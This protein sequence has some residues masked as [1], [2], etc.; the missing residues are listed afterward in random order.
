MDERLQKIGRH[1]LERLDSLTDDLIGGTLTPAQYRE[2]VA[3]ALITDQAAAYMLGADTKRL[4]LDDQRTI[5][6]WNKFQLGYLDG[7]VSD[8]E[9]GRYAD[10]EAMLRARAR[11]YA[12]AVKAPY[13]AGKAQG[14]IIP[15]W[16]L[17]GLQ[18]CRSNCKCRLSDVRDNGD[19]SG[20][21]SRAMNG[22]EPHCGT[23]PGLV[24]D[25]VVYRR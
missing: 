3:R 9:S 12:G 6:Q 7:F 14:W 2:A 19:G 18:E 16:L 13:Y 8:I 20:V 15:D 23:C 1:L 11:M 21:I 10:S 17:P 24:G 22:P 4:T 25:H 5:T